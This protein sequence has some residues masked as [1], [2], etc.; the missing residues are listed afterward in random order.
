MSTDFAFNSLVVMMLAELAKRSGH[1]FLRFPALHVSGIKVSREF[2][3]PLLRE[4]EGRGRA[5]KSIGLIIGIKERHKAETAV[6]GIK[7]VRKSSK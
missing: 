1:P 2:S 6:A 7:Q 5:W 3:T 4:T